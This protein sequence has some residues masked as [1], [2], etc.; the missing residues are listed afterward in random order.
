MALEVR[1]TKRS[2][3]STII[4]FL[5]ALALQLGLAPQ[6]ELFGGRVNVMAALLLAFAPGMEAGPAA[7]LGFAAGLSFDLSQPVPLGLMALVLTIAGF[8]LASASRG[9]LGGLNRDTVRLVAIAAV[10]LNVLYAICLLLLGQVDGILIAIGVHGLVSAALDVAMAC[11]FL[12]FNGPQD[13]GL[14]FSG[15]GSSLGSGRAPKAGGLHA[16]HFSM[17]KSQGKR[18]KR[19]KTLG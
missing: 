6:I 11:A 17:G 8:V 5:V 14:G 18:F 3:R 10:L 7:L 2:R 4:M 16:G 19:Y 12:Y 9:T 1:D 13:S 15:S